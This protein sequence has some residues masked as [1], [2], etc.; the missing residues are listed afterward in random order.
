M[1]EV[2]PPP[3]DSLVLHVE[4]DEEDVHFLDA[5]VDGYDGVANVRREYRIVND[6]QQFLLYT[7]PGLVDFTVALIR[8]LRS[9]IYIGRISVEG[10]VNEP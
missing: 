6:N 8:E 7:S 1:G 10:A 3:E 9:Y 4:V 5:I 2:P